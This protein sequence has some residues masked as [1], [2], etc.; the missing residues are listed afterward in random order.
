MHNNSRL[1]IFDDRAM[2]PG[3]SLSSFPVSDPLHYHTIFSIHTQV[4]SSLEGLAFVFPIIR[5]L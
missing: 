1:A 3:N 5:P 2:L 4:R